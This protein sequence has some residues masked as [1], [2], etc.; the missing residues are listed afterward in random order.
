MNTSLIQQITGWLSLIAPLAV[1]IMMITLAF[2]SRRFGSVTQAKPYYWGFFV[3]AVFVIL[4]AAARGYILWLEHHR[5][6]YDNTVWTLIYNGLMAAGVITGL[7]SA[8]RYWSWL[9]AER[10]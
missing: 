10:D 2:L 3:G 1:L 6:L 5:E 7:I 8:W 4:A 9:L